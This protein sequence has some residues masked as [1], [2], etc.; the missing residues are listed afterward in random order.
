MGVDRVDL[1]QPPQIFQTVD[2]VEFVERCQARGNHRGDGGRKI[3]VVD[4]AMS[5]YAGD[6]AEVD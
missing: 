4:D 2:G 6:G 5:S 3:Q 1:N